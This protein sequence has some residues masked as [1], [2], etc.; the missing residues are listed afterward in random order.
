MTGC[1]ASNKRLRHHN[2]YIR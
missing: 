2:I 1:D